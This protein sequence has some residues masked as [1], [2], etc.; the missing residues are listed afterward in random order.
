[1]N[2]PCNPLFISNLK[3]LF[4]QI[5]LSSVPEINEAFAT[6]DKEFEEKYGFPKPDKTASNIVLACR[7]G[8]RVLKALE[9]L[10]SIGYNSFR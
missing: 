8:V 3:D 2:I 6:E 9:S 5:L 1:M 4:K 7:S 10:Q